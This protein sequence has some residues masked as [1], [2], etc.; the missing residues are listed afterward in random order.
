MLKNIV[1][2]KIMDQPQIHNL[3]IEFFLLVII[4]SSNKGFNITLRHVLGWSRLGMMKHRYIYSYF[5]QR[6]GG[7]LY[8]RA[9]TDQ[10]E[11]D[12]TLVS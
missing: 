7:R 5:M 6:E 12:A 9:K 8:E 3:E 4:N 11:Y 2:S 1:R 10:Q